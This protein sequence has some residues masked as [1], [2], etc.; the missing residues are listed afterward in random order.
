MFHQKTG[1][2]RAVFGFKNNTDVMG[3]FIADIAEH[4][5]F[6][7]HQQLGDFLNQFGFDDLIGNF[8]YDNL[9]LSVSEVFLL[10]FGANAESSLSLPIG[11]KNA[12][13]TVDDNA[14]G[15]EI[16]PL[17]A[18]NQRFHF[19]VGFFDQI[20]K[21][22]TDLA[23]VMRRDIG[24]HADGNSRRT[25]A[26]Q[27][28]YHGRHDDRF[29]LFA[30]IGFAKIDGIVVETFHQSHGKFSQAGFGITHGGRTVAV[31]ITEV[32]LAVNQ[33]IT[34]GKILSQAHHGTVN[35]TVAVR[36]IFTDDIADDTGAFLK[37]GLRIQMQLA[38]GKKQTAVNRFQSVADI[39]Q[40]AVDNGRHG[41]RQ[42]SF[43][44]FLRE[45]N[46]SDFFFYFL[47]VKNTLKSFIGLSYA[48]N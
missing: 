47:H 45:V 1:V 4:R 30:V 35:R 34:Y 26:E 29:F 22:V 36:M 13:K 12:F 44:Q 48:A 10:P 14:A 11:V 31:D 17:D 5:Q 39:R 43:A 32:S 9:I 33:R 18:A 3:R 19:A 42:V 27:I 37:T 21:R 25:V 16:R 7:I 6:F 38:H 41:I 8:G 40:R 24:G 23:E 46:I 2:D 28:G 20:Q 15:R